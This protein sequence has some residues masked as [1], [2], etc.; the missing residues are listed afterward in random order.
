MN[1]IGCTAESHEALLEKESFED[2][3]V[4]AILN[5]HY[6]AIKKDR[7]ERP[8]VDK[9]YMLATQLVT[10]RSGWPKSLWLTPAG[11][12]WMAGH[13]HIGNGGD[14]GRADTTTLRCDALLLAVKLSSQACA[15]ERCLAPEELTLRLPVEIQ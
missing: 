5:E 2:P 12:P 3:E 9:T 11:E 6:V 7:E 8:D 14:V 15:A 1:G 13:T 10:G 4:A